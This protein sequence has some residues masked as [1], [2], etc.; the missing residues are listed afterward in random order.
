M[1]D[2]LADLSRDINADRFRNLFVGVLA[3]GLGD[4]SAPK[5]VGHLGN[6]VGDLDA[7]GP[8]DGD[9][10]GGSSV[11]FSLTL[12]MVSVSLANLLSLEACF[13]WH[14]KLLHSNPTDVIQIKKMVL[15]VR[16]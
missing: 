9:A 15:R 8:R 1:R 5:L 4:Q 14:H 12:V 6:L 11:A 3:L 7:M 13:I 16:M 2:V 10:L